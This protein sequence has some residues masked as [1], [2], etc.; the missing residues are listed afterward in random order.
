MQP[1]LV[2]VVFEYGSDWR[3]P[4]HRLRDGDEEIVS[5]FVQRREGLEED[6][7]VGASPERTARVIHLQLELREIPLLHLHIRCI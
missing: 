6:A 7:A 5:L 2:Q 1:R 4:A 3:E